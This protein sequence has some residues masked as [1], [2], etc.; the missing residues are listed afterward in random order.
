[1]LVPQAAKAPLLGV[2]VLR[3]SEYCDILCKCTCQAAFLGI[4]CRHVPCLFP[5][6]LISR[7]VMLLFPIGG[8]PILL[9]LGPRRSKTGRQ[10]SAVGGTP[11]SG[12]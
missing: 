3:V 10:S 12:K 2:P 11:Y 8:G 4:F 6:R 5:N 9:V 1:M 7:R